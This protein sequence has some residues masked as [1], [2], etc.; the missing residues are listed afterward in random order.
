MGLSCARVSLSLTEMPE[1]KEEGRMTCPGR[2]GKTAQKK[3]KM[4]IEYEAG[5]CAADAGGQQAENR[6]GKKTSLVASA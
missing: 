5:G 2:R 4:N 3:T 6:C 1:R